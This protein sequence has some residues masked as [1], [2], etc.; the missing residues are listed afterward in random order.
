MERPRP[1]GEARNAAQKVA[2]RDDAVVAKAD[3]GS[4]VV[5]EIH[6]LLRIVTFSAVFSCS[7]IL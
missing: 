5:M 4:A 3:A 7:F 6:R 2:P 1:R